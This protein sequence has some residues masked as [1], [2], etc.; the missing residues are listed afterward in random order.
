MGPVPFAPMPLPSQARRCCN[1]SAIAALSVAFMRSTHPFS[2]LLPQ[3][4]G[5]MVNMVTAEHDHLDRREDTTPVSFGQVAGCLL[6]GTVCM[7][8][9]L[10]LV[11]RASPKSDRA[12]QTLLSSRHHSPLLRDG[13]GVKEQLSGSSW[14]VHKTS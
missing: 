13:A 11:A 9:I 1:T 6:V 2:L 4:T 12:P 3:T 10:R 7:M 14:L 5:D 8:L